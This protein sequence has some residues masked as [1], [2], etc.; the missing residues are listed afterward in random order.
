MSRVS[1]RNEVLVDW[2]CGPYSAIKKYDIV[3]INA[4]GE[5]SIVSEAVIVPV[6][7]K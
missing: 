5:D 1:R 7:S 4:Q 3:L 6:E 2:R